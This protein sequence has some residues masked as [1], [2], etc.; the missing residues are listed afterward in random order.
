MGFEGEELRL[1]LSYERVVGINDRRTVKWL[2]RED[3][4]RSLSLLKSL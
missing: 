2:I 3:T 4:Y 1:Q